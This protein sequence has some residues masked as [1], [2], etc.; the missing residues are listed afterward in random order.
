MCLFSRCLIKCNALIWVAAAGALGLKTY[1]EGVPWHSTWLTSSVQASTMDYMEDTDW[2]EQVQ[3]A[4]GGLLA[5]P[6]L[7]R[8]KPE[9]DG[10]DPQ[11]GQQKGKGRGKGKG[12]NR[13]LDNHQPQQQ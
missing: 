10:E 13:H 11:D 1:R 9:E 6:P 8:A 3:D 2:L 12:K 5:R 4:V 7:K